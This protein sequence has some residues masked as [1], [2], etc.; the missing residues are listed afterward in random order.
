MFGDIAAVVANGEHWRVAVLILAAGGPGIQAFQTMDA[1]LFHQLVQRSVN[2]ER[3]LE[4]R[5]LQP[6]QQLVGAK[7]LI[8]FS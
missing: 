1:S 6:V 2:L 4:T 8:G 5:R 7:R 3:G